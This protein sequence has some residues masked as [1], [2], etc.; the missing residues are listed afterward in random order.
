MSKDLFDRLKALKLPGM[1]AALAEQR[2]KG[3]QYAQMGFEERLELLVE[4]E[5]AGRN[6][7]R[8]ERLVRNAGY[9]LPGAHIRNLTYVSERGLDRKVLSELY[10]C[11]YIR[12]N[13]NIVIEGASGTGKTYLACALGV[14]ANSQGYRTRYVNYQEM[15]DLLVLDAGKGGDTKGSFHDGLV[16]SSVLIIDDWLLSPLRTEAAAVAVYGVLDA[17]ERKETPTIFC[18]QCQRKDWHKNLWQAMIADSIC[19]RILTNFYALTL[20]GESMRKRYGFR[21]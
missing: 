3:P 16:S 17:R 15:C 4:S 11:N 18:T 1:A 9:A 12:N 14:Q 6:E 8:T 5:E 10:T 20:K 13:N 7:R 21:G 2:Q 19:D